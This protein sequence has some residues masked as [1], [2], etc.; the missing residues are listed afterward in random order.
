MTLRY[1]E[2]IKG[3]IKTN[4]LPIFE[5]LKGKNTDIKRLIISCLL[6]LIRAAVIKR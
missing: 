5:P 2:I 6:Q 3:I 4:F 1:I